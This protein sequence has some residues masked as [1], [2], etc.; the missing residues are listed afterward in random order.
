MQFITHIIKRINHLRYRGL[1]YGEE[2]ALTL[3]RQLRKAWKKFLNAPEANQFGS[4]PGIFFTLQEVSC[5]L[6]DARVTPSQLAPE[7][8]NF[9]ELTYWL[10]YESREEVRRGNLWWSDF[11]QE[12]EIRFGVCLLQWGAF[13]SMLMFNE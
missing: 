11:G 3:R 10:N 5:S 12:N 8:S 2:H 13:Y 9:H 6:M 7:I 1:P 4:L